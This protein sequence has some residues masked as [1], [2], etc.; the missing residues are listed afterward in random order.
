MRTKVKRDCMIVGLL[1]VTILFLAACTKDRMSG[2]DWADLARS[3][4]T[5]KFGKDA[6]GQTLTW[7]YELG[8]WE[9]KGGKEV[10]AE[11]NTVVRIDCDVPPKTDQ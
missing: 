6:C 5:P 3:A 8:R 4:A 10:V 9:I 7:S 11:N 2:V 1:A